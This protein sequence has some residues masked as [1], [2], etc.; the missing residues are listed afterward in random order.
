MPRADRPARSPGDHPV[1]TSFHNS[2]TPPP[3]AHS[4]QRQL[5]SGSVPDHTPFSRGRGVVRNRARGFARR[6]RPQETRRWTQCGRAA[7]GDRQGIL[8]HV[9]TSWTIHRVCAESEQSE[10]TPPKCQENNCDRFAIVCT[11]CQTTLAWPGIKRQWTG[12]PRDC[13]ASAC[14]LCHCAE[15]PLLW[16]GHHSAE[17]VL[18][19]LI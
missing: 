11:S 16:C 2:F 14:R 10:Q 1:L 9:E 17:H 15:F 13:S 4:S 3:D 5:N 8:A 18:G 6:V 7:G 12:V 19:R